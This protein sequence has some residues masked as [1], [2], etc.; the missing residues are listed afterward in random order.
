MAAGVTVLK[1][2]TSSAGRPSGS[3][4]VATTWYWAPKGSSRPGSEVQ[5]VP[6]SETV[7]GNGPLEPLTCTE[8]SRPL[9]TVRLTGSV[10][11]TPAAD[12]AGCREI[13]A[14]VLGSPVPALAVS[15]GPQP[16]ALSPTAAAPT[17]AT[18]TRPPSLTAPPSHHCSRVRR[19]RKHSQVDFPECNCGVITLRAAHPEK[20]GESQNPQT[21]RPKDPQTGTR[22][23]SARGH[24]GSTRT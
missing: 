19:A 17:I 23:A 6:S 8:V 1:V 16:D 14:S 3:T 20:R 18:N 4:A 15:S 22:S 24:R 21:S 11:D 10:T 7:P 5:V 2:S 9:S 13:T 12:G